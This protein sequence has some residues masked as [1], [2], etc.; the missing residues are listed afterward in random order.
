MNTNKSKSPGLDG[1]PYAF[2]QNFPPNCT[3]YLLDIFNIILKYNV[4]PTHWRHGFV[5]PI[6][7]PNKNKHLT[8][9]YRPIT[10]LSTLCKL[11]EKI[12]NRR[13][14]W[15]LEKIKYISPEQNEFRQ[16]R[17]TLNNV[18]SIKHEIET[19]KNNR[20]S[21]GMISF[22]I[23]KAYDTTWRPRII[24]IL[25]K[26]VC[27]GNLINF[28]QNLLLERTFQVKTSKCLSDIYIQENGVPQGSTISVTLFLL[29]INDISKQ[30]AKPITS[31][32]YANDFSILCRSNNI[33]TIKQILQNATK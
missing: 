4:F 32:L 8:E 27:K 10:L 20:Q 31:L 3:K 19:T 22:D 1:I 21:L 28:I 7:K 18:L 12:I 6:L 29:A 24:H 15:F 26:I 30:I 13:L 11:L 25:N 16:N 5:I 17:N 14:A 23:A 33:T 2:I 9:S